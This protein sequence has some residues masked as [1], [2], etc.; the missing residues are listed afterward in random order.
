MSDTDVRN[1]EQVPREMLEAFQQTYQAFVQR[2][3]KLEVAYRSMQEDFKKVNIEL[4]AK[5]AQLQESLRKQG[6]MQTYLTSILE[7]MDSGVVGIDISGAITHFN[8]AAARTIGHE[9]TE[10]LGKNYSSV[11]PKQADSEDS[12]LKVLASGKELKQDEKVIWHKDGH[13]IPVWFQTAV[14]RDN[15]R[16]KLGAV[17]IFSDVSRIKALEEEMQKT[18][19]MAALGEMAATVAH[20]VRNPL[21]AMGMWVGL[22]ERDLDA[23]DPRKKIVGRVME[24]LARLNRIVS[25][26]LVYSRPVRANFHRV[27]MADVL[28]EIADFVQIEIERQNQSI[29]VEK[30][31][32]DET[33][34]YVRIDPEKMHQVV[35]NLCLNAVQAMPDGGSLSVHLDDVPHRKAGYV[36]F[37]IVD[38][39]S[40]IDSETLEKMFDPF[41]TTKENGTGLGLAIVKKL[42]EFHRGHIQVDSTVGKGTTVHVFLPCEPED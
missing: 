2:A 31:W 18:R 9:V 39:G 13:P 16:G 33:S 8:K 15:D 40:G 26:L 17:E 30:K 42:V 29:T 3:E 12:L 22:L 27:N 24:G 32:S 21:G 25:N 36:S 34:A 19:T 23:E 41:F 28:G 20:E 5:N 1:S 35:M 38:T 6:E 37:R 7:S 14:L 4:D 11:F 10:V